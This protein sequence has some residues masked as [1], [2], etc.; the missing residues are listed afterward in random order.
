MHRRR[1]R[2]ARTQGIREAR[3]A[4]PT[5]RS[6]VAAGC[7]VLRAYLR[8]AGLCA[9]GW[10]RWAAPRRA[11]CARLRRAARPASGGSAAPARSAPPGS[12]P[13]GGALGAR[14]A[15]HAARGGRGA[16][17]AL[18]RPAAAGKLLIWAVMSGEVAGAGPPTSF[19]SLPR[20]S[21]CQTRGPHCLS[22][23]STAWP[24]AGPGCPGSR[25]HGAAWRRSAWRLGLGI[26]GWGI[27][28]SSSHWEGLRGRLHCDRPCHCGHRPSL[29]ARPGSRAVISSQALQRG[30]TGKPCRW[31]PC[32][33]STGPGGCLSPFLK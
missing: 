24:P 30:Q 16:G 3:T 20:V 26:C 7:S 33:G 10:L 5:R 13:P 15:A 23:A 2:A 17:A 8:P 4:A 25:G 19:H 9:S 29:P 22:G 28:G 18:G 14:L 32:L 12:A 11:S 1:A 31:V 21:C 27:P 6:L